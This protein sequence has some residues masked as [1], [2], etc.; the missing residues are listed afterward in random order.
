MCKRRLDEVDTYQAALFIQS[1]AH[2]GCGIGGRVPER[3]QR[4]ACLA[5]QRYAELGH[6]A[7][8]LFALLLRF[9]V[10]EDGALHAEKYF[11]T[12]QEEHAL[13]L[14]QHRPLLL[15]ALARVSASEFGNPAPGCEAATK[16][17]ST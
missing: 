16:L 8:P 17:L 6:D 10:S 5:A 11:R 12:V 15:A 1:L 13:A 4:G 3:D 9:A 14:P 7:K 2:G